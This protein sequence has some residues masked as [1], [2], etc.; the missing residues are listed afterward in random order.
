L[1]AAKVHLSDP[2][3]ARKANSGG[4]VN[5]DELRDVQARLDDVTRQQAVITEKLA[6]MIGKY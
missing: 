5:A 1:Y 3:L 4:V 6:K 2:S